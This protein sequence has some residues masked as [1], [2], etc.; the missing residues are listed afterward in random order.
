M[1]TG[2]R[3]KKPCSQ[4]KST[5]LFPEEGGFAL[6]SEPCC[7]MINRYLYMAKLLSLWNISHLI[8]LCEAQ[9]DKTSGNLGMDSIIEEDKYFSLN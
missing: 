9:E 3:T 7:R 2:N 4:T 8:K 5:L 1:A 6:P